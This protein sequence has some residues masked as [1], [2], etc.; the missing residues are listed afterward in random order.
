MTFARFSL[1]GLAGAVV[2]CALGLACLMF[3]SSPWTS[4]VLSF[5]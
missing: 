1:A 3:A 2:L 4:V 5:T